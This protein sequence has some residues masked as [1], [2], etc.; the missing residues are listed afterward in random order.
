V[1]LPIIHQRR[2]SDIAQGALLS[3]QSGE[4]NLT[5]AGAGHSPKSLRSSRFAGH[6]L[7]ILR[8]LNSVARIDGFPRAERNHLKST[9]GSAFSAVSWWNSAA[10][11]TV[12]C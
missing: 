12:Q 6:R 11:V 9:H 2:D 3:R 4:R 1:R 7:A 8:R 10:L 5:A